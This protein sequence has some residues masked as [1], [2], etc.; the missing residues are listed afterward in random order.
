MV[1]YENGTKDIFNEEK[2]D[3]TVSTPTQSSGDLFIQ[4]QTDASDI[5]KDI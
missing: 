2:K 5:I 1:R 4:G 3:E